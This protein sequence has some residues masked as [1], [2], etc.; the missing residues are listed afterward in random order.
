MKALVAQEL[1]GPA[2]LKFTDVD[3]VSG[4][5]VVVIDVGA[6]GVSF[7]DLLLLRGEYQL[8]LDPP[9]IPGMEVAGVVRSAPE[10][11]E[12]KPGQRVTALSM[13]GGWAERVAVPAGQLLPVPDRLSVVEAAALPEATCTIWG[14]LM[15][16]A[17]LRPGETVLVHG[18][19]GGI[20]TMAIQ[21]ARQVGARVATTAGSAERLAAC[22]GLGAEILI[23]H[24]R[25]DFVAEV[26]AATDGRGADVV[27][28]VIGAPYLERNVQVLAPDGRLVVIGL[29]G[30]RRVEIDL[31][32]LMARRA[33]LFAPTLRNR[34]LEQKAAIV[35]SVL[36]HVWPLLVDGVVRPVIHATLP[37]AEA[38]QAHRLVESGVPFGKLLLTP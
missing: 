10:E 13:L 4:D 14:T 33:T 36:E 25:Q 24:H 22:A 20:G 2:G 6:A 12:F 5:N 29:Q 8:R 34:P 7:P 38:A 37:L 27:L 3:D 32:A 30:G 19:S 15:M 23:D 26:L 1:S 31:G 11:S 28:D 21:L 18:G 35:A 17:G 16:L 9:F